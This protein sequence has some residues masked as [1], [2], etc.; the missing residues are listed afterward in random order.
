MSH[1]DIDNN[2]PSD[3]N[4]WRER[5]S[6]YP[7]HVS[8]IVQRTTRKAKHQQSLTLHLIGPS[9]SF[10]M[11]HRYAQTC[12]GDILVIVNPYTLFP[13]YTQEA[14]SHSF[15]SAT[16]LT[17]LQQ[18]LSF[19]HHEFTSWV[20]QTEGKVFPR[21]IVMDLAHRLQ[22]HR[23]YMSFVLRLGWWSLIVS[24]RCLVCSCE[25]CRFDHGTVVVSTPR[26]WLRHIL[27]RRRTMR[28]RTWRAPA[29]RNASLSGERGPRNRCR[30]I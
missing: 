4:C 27:L 17:R 21:C 29:K 8:K 20:G 23:V 18:T 16:T 7:L 19:Q 12:V 22:V 2:G 10:N 15:P 11:T 9:F 6:S 24:T 3:S 1:S 28:T 14:S 25:L 13:I 5:L 26:T 30:F